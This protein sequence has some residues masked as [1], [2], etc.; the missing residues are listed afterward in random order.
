M[1]LDGSL[2]F[3]IVTILFTFSE[4]LSD[5]VEHTLYFTLSTP[6]RES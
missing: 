2:Y 4:E 6:E 3:T 1:K 5:I